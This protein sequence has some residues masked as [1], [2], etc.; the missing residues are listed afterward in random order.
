[1][2][3]KIALGLVAV[4]AVVG[5]VAAMSAYEAHVIN[6]TAHIENALSVPTEPI[7][8]GTVFPQEY[9]A[10]P[11]T[12]TL[13]T[14]FQSQEE[15]MTVFY[16]I[17]QKAKCIC[18]EEGI[19]HQICKEGEYAAVDYATDEC[20]T[21][22]VPDTIAPIVIHPYDEM[23][24]LCPF[25]SKLPQDGEPGDTG[26]PSYFVP[27]VPGQ[28][29]DSCQV[30]TTGANGI[31]AMNREDVS[32]SWLVDLKVPPFAGYVG[33]DWPANCPVLEGANVNADGTDLGCDL[34]IEVTRI[35]RAEA[36]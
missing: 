20:P 1:M 3:K 14:S 23:I 21:A 12:I 9:L 27:G 35:D 2:K 29:E 33:Q 4:V 30:V 10:K 17:N 18:N 32:D 15:A 19:S 13:S 22:E 5:G 24:S 16:E 34:W 7:V 25:L 31:L 6:V 28:I 8:F 11:F 36:N 26:E